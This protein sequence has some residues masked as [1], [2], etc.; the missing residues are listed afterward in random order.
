MKLSANKYIMAY[1]LSILLGLGFAGGVMYS[2][3]PIPQQAAQIPVI[4]FEN[5]QLPND[6]GIIGASP[7]SG[8]SIISK[9]APGL[10]KV[11][12]MPSIPG[13]PEMPGTQAVLTVIGVLP[14][15]VVIMQKGPDTVTAKVGSRTQFGVVNSVSMNGAVIDGAFVELKR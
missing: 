10:P 15:D 11:P 3:E 5:A 12:E 8:S 13:V 1:G 4:N 2:T 7:F 6:V 14:P 9:K